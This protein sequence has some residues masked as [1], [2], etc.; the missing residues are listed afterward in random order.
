M[1]QEQRPLISRMV[2]LYFLTSI[3]WILVTD[4]PKHSFFS[5]DIQKGILFILASSLLLHYVINRYSRKWESASQA[6]EYNEYKFMAVFEQ[7]NDGI[8][9]FE[10][11]AQEDE[12]RLIHANDVFCQMVGLSRDALYA[13]RWSSRYDTPALQLLR[14]VV[15]ETRFQQ[16]KRLELE[17]HLDEHSKI[18][19][20]VQARYMDFGMKPVIVIVCKDIT[21]RKQSERLISHLSTHDLMTDLPNERFFY[22][23]LSAMQDRVDTLS[24]C[25]IQIDQLHLTGRMYDLSYKSQLLKSLGLQIRQ[26]LKEGEL[27]CLTAESLFMVLLR[28]D[29]A[30][31]HHEHWATRLCGRLKEPVVIQEEETFPHIHVG[32]AV[33]QQGSEDAGEL[34]QLAYFQLG[35]AVANNSM[36][37][38][39]TEASRIAFSSSIILEK[40]LRRAIHTDELELYYQPKVCLTEHRI[41]GAEALIRWNHPKQGLKGPGAFVPFAEE[42]GLIVPIGEWVI[43]QACR[44]LK[45]WMELGMEPFPIAVNL[46]ARQFLHG[47]IVET[48]GSIL[49]GTDVDPAWLHIEITESMSIES[50][51][52]IKV[53]NRIRQLGVQVSMDDFGTGYSSLGCLKNFPIDKVKIDKAFIQDMTVDGRGTK[54]VEAI[55]QMVHALELEVV[56]EGVETLEQYSLLRSLKCDELQGYLISKPLPATAFYKYVN[57]C[58]GGVRFAAG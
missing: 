55:I 31:H 39:T 22:E 11:T 12:L 48:I 1:K 3:A 21:E 15:A 4:L 19:L 53:M 30:D 29:A 27:V 6:L 9:V 24:I 54:M 32:L 49:H 34:V 40:E 46:S 14:Q 50:E 2:T 57:D 41:C 26:S 45:E 47:D 7:S 23:Q 10:W 58:R 17:L 16:D 18:V 51:Q 44:Q 28:P 52:M 37:E 25:V 13:E 8:T 35:Q 5:V 42:I 56:A 43:R 38:I 36:L 33:G 20:D